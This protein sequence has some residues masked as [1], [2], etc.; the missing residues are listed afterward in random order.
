MELFSIWLVRMCCLSFWGVRV[1]DIA[2]AI[3]ALRQP[4]FEG[5]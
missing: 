3:F 2:G 5:N 4:F 1:G